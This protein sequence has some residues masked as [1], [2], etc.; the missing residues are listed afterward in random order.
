MG[1]RR[2]GEIHGNWSDCACVAWES[3]SILQF[4]G[5]LPAA[6]RWQERVQGS[7]DSCGSLR[8]PYFAQD[9]SL[10]KSHTLRMTKGVCCANLWGSPLDPH[11]LAIH[12]VKGVDALF[13]LRAVTAAMVAARVEIFL[14]DLTDGFVLELDLVAECERLAGGRAA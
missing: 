3:R 6:V 13:L 4:R 14:D 9:D 2:G 12:L 1:I 11:D 5:E 7:F 10:R 8:S